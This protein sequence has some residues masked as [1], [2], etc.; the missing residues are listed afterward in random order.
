[1]LLD[2]HSLYQPE[3]A[4]AP[5]PPFV[6]PLPPKRQQKQVV[7]CSIG[8]ELPAMESESVA[9]VRAVARIDAVLPPALVMVAA[10]AAYRDTGLLRRPDDADDEDLLLSLGAMLL[11]DDDDDDDDW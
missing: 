11:L 10:V 1:M 6:W 3:P 4:P 8:G 5:A 9:T 7:A 2:Y